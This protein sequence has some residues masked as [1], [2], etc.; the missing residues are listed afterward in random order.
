MNPVLIAASRG[1]TYAFKTG[2]AEVRTQSPLP[3]FQSDDALV[4]YTQSR[5]GAETCGKWLLD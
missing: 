1:P 2:S 3:F 5:S 4:Y